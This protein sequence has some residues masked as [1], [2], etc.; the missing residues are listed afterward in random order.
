ICLGM[1]MMTRGS[2]E[3]SMRGLGWVDADTLKFPLANN[4]KVPHMGWNQVRP[5]PSASLF[6]SNPDESERFYFV[7]SYFVRADNPLHAAAY[8]RYGHDFVASLEVENIMGVQFHPEKSHLFGM[9][10]FRKFI[11]L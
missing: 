6:E 8:C 5:S 1:Q 11:A 10:L 4:L 7:H 2:E 3:G 9:N